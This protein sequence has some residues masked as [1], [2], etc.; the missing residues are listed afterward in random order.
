MPKEAPYT[1][2]WSAVHQGYTLYDRHVGV[3]LP[4]DEGSLAWREW[5]EQATSFAFHGQRGTYTA[6]REQIKPDDWYWYAYQ[7]SQKRVRKKYLGKSAALSLQRLEEV[8]ASFNH[9]PA[10]EKE[11][12]SNT[13]SSA[14]DNT[15]QEPLL[16]AKLR[17]PLA[18]QH[19]VARARLWAC[20]Q[21]ALERSVTLLSAPA[22]SGKS[23]LI[24]SWLR[25]CPFPSAWLSLD[26]A[27]NDAVCFWP[28]LFTALDTLYPRV[29]EHALQVLRSLRPPT[30]EG[31]LTLLIN[32][33]GNGKPTLREEAGEVLLVLDDYHM[34]SNEAIHQGMAFLLEH[35]PPH[36]HLIISTRNDP[37][38]PLARLR[39]S[40]RL[41]EL[42]AADL[43]FNREEIVIFMNRQ[44]DVTLSAEEVALIEERT[45]G[46]A[47]GLQLMALVLHDQ[48]KH[49]DIL[50]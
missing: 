46:W 28:Y 21:G 40:G 19:L 50:Q 49:P 45:A 20:L 7:R 30:I 3:T 10:A 34:I 29:G 24:S 32:Q 11:S 13:T 42:R 2:A 33:L 37:P 16:A 18:P 15:A 25:Q 23:T 12:A 44:T 43:R 31:V 47:T 48:H 1:L 9:R 39:V 8:A 14:G 26:Q 41:L 27:D 22:G 35:L 4:L 6:R 17:V 5:L 38:L 36:L